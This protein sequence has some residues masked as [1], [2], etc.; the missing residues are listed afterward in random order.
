LKTPKPSDAPF[1]ARPNRNADPP[2]AA[3]TI[4]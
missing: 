4:M 3:V 2:L 1:V